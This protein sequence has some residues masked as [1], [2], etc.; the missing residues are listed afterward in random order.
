MPTI[1]P[2]VRAANDSPIVRLEC[3]KIIE[4]AIYANRPA[5]SA[6]A[7]AAI[8]CQRKWPRRMPAAIPYTASSI[9]MIG[10]M[11]GNGM[12]DTRW[13]NTGDNSPTIA[14]PRHP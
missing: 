2:G 13:L 1:R 4:E 7:I 3:N 11:G 5:T 12:P 10:T 6:A 14:P 8:P 9:V